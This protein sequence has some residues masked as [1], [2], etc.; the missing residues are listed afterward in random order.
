MTDEVLNGLGYTDTKIRIPHF[1]FVVRTQ[2]YGRVNS[3]VNVAIVL[4][5]YRLAEALLNNVT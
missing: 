5:G 1:P 2:F 4:S 3:A